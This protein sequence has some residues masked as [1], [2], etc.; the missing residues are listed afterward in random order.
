MDNFF[1][2]VLIIFTTVLI[3]LFI[4]WTL[5]YFKRQI[6]ESPLFIGIKE[7]TPYAKALT[8]DPK[9]NEQIF[10][11]YSYNFQFYISDWE[12]NYGQ[13]KLIFYRGTTSGTKI[14]CNPGVWLYP[15]QTSLM[16]RVDSNDKYIHESSTKTDDTC[17][18]HKK[19]CNVK[20]DDHNS[21]VKDM[22]PINAYDQAVSDSASPSNNYTPSATPNHNK[23]C[24]ITNLPIQKWIMLSLVM[25]HG[26][27]DVYIDGVLVRSCYGIAPK[28]YGD[29]IT[30]NPEFK[31]KIKNFQYFNHT[32]NANDIQRLY[33]NMNIYTDLQMVGGGVSN[34]VTKVTSSL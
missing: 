17:N 21:F 22:N 32:L 23:Y 25:F 5:G 9:V 11:E 30:I 8:F 6:K 3:I 13:P 7:D 14:M 18:N 2:I 15:K 16:I 29:N 4:M 33:N 12:Y 31:G 24:D 26:Q 27:L 20:I 28:H 19:Q 10:N 34:A 1:N